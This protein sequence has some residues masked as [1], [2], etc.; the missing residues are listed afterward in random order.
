MADS[1]ALTVQ[2]PEYGL[3][4]EIGSE[5]FGIGHVAAALQILFQVCLSGMDRSA[6]GSDLAAAEIDQEFF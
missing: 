5:L 4:N 1:G 6:H 2:H 3:G